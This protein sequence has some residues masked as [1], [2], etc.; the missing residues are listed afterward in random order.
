MH[1][2]LVGQSYTVLHVITIPVVHPLGC[3]GADARSFTFI[4]ILSRIHYE[5]GP[6]ADGSRPPSFQRKGSRVL[7]PKELHCTGRAQAMASAMAGTRLGFRSLRV[8]L[9]THM[10]ARNQTSVLWW[11]N[12]PL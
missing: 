1:G 3:G 6:F 10:R 12:M 5:E 4:T 2:Q 7:K 9:G 8:K 11:E